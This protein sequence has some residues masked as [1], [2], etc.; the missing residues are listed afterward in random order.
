MTDGDFESIMRKL[1]GEQQAG[2]DAQPPQPGGFAVSMEK[3]LERQRIFD[4]LGA[5]S[6]VVKLVLPACVEK[7]AESQGPEE[8]V[9]YAMRIADEFLAQFHAKARDLGLS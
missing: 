9:A 3:V 8:I 2:R 5:I 4:Q 6:A 1:R 7:L